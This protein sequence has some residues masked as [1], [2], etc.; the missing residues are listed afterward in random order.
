VSS[1]SKIT[2]FLRAAVALRSV[3]LRGLP[4]IPKRWWPSLPYNRT[5]YN[6]FILWIKS[7]GLPSASWVVDVGA[8]HGDFAQAASTVFPNAKVLLIEP[9]PTLQAELKRRCLEYQPRWF[10]ESCAAGARAGTGE[11]VMDAKDDAIGSLFGFSDEYLRVNPSV[12]TA[13]TIA[14]SIK[15]L[16]Q[17]L[18]ERKIDHVGLVKIDVEGF[19]FEVLDGLQKLLPVV[20]SII[21]EVSL[22]RHAKT[23]FDP[24][25]NMTNRLTKSGFEIVAA[26]PSVYA[27]DE[28]R[29]PVEFNILARR[30]S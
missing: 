16:D 9:L 15:P 4:L 20:R 1:I 5:A 2:T 26:I 14:C 13:A 3:H 23:D 28:M 19:E 8:N 29:R 24:V 11:L 21:V 30:V 27:P 18:T 22:V 7:L 10:L 17:I 12:A 6:E 25:A